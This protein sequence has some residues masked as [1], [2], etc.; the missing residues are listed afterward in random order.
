MAVCVDQSGHQGLARDI[1]NV[2][3]KRSSR[4]SVH[5]HDAV[6]LDDDDGLLRYSVRTPSK[7]LAFKNVVRFM[8]YPQAPPLSKD[9][10]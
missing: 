4:R 3:A 8:S 2:P 7:I 10:I 9:L 6:A 1:D 5:R